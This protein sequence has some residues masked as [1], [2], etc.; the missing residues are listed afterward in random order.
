MGQRGWAG[1]G[2][3]TTRLPSAFPLVAGLHPGGARPLMG[4]GDGF[5]GSHPAHPRRPIAVS[6]VGRVAPGIAH[7]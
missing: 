6:L 1:W 4:D 3:G 7:A 5:P 2:L